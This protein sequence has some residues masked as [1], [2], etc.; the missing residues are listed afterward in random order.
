M[1]KL[2]VFT[3]SCACLILWHFTTLSNPNLEILG[4]GEF[5]IYSREAINSPLIIRRL[6]MGSGFIY[7]TS[8]ENAAELRQKFNHIDGESITLN[9]YKPVRDIL[10]L[11]GHTKI[12][13]RKDSVMHITYAYSGRGREFI[14]HNGKRINLQIAH[15]GNRT[16]IGW[17]VILGSF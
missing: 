6:D 2:C 13:S 3:A 4:S 15:R 5:S 8:S 14:E 12:S 9:R 16:A 7:V 11:L 10:A 17:P 1:F